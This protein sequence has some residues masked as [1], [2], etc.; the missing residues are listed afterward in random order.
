MMAAEADGE[1]GARGPSQGRA[2][3]LTGQPR[4][5]AADEREQFCGHAGT[6]GS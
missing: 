3:W 6:F 4:E 5:H 1:E 2:E